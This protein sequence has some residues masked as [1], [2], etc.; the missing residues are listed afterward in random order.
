MAGRKPQKRS[1]KPLRTSKKKPMVLGKP[2]TDAK[3][4]NVASA[5][6]PLASAA[7]KSASKVT[8]TAQRKK[9]THTALGIIA[10]T[11]NPRNKPG[12]TYSAKELGVPE[13]NTALKPAGLVRTRGKKGK[14]FADHAA[15]ERLLTSVTATNEGKLATKVERVKM[16]E[17]VR[18]ARLKEMEAKEQAKRDKVRDKMD[19]LKRVRKSKKPAADEGP[20]KKAVRFV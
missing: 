9:K 11:S 5:A 13:L 7:P 3:S 2:Q 10:K 15:M 16:L 18:E 14:V 6:L 4:R 8:K 12:R 17:Q 19:E 1:A 20:K